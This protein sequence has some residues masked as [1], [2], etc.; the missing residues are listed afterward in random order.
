MGSTFLGVEIGRSALQAQRLA[1]EVTGDNIAN[2]G[3]PGYTR[4]QPVF[5]PVDLFAEATVQA[6]TGVVR[7]GTGVS[8]ERVR[9]VRDQYL[10]EQLRA[11]GSAVAYWEA[12]RDALD[13]V[14]A[15]FP[16]PSAEGL[17]EALDGFWSAWEELAQNPQE[18]APRAAIRERADALAGRLKYLAAELSR[19]GADLAALTADGV[20]RINEL[21]DRLADLN[22]RIRALG[23]RVDNHVL[24]ER[25][26]LLGELSGLMAVGV[27]ENDDGTVTVTGAGQTLVDGFEARDVAEE[28]LAAVAG[29]PGGK[30][31]ALLEARAEV[32]AYRAK[33][34]DF[35]GAL[36]LRVNEAYGDTFFVFDGQTIGLN[37]DIAASADNIVAGRS[38]YAGDNTVAVAVAGLREVPVLEGLTFGQYYRQLVAGVGEARAGAEAGVAAY[39]RVRDNLE[40]LR[41]G[42]SGVSLD[43]ELTYLM[44][45]RYAFEA[46]AR[47]I[48]TLDEMLDTLVNRL[49]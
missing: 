4:Q 22:Q 19:I 12:L 35:T 49:R 3:T 25:D 44:Q 8:V 1:L 9:R 45:Y 16:E 6:Q 43:E 2:A 23:S 34:A 41:E 32:E 37:G 14:E 15:L 31:G 18:Q 47:Y 26:R 33:L 13:R 29:G 28:D 46:A 11:A 7:L 24:D 42:V 17:Q 20:S 30:L 36:A 27:V 38:G 10:E 39:G 48:S 5:A 21:A 40:T